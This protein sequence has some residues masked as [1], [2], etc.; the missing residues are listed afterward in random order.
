MKL[1]CYVLGLLNIGFLL[2][3]FH[4]GKLNLFAPPPDVYSPILLV[5]EYARAQ[6][7][8][9]ISSVLDRQSMKLAGSGF[10]WIRDARPRLDSRIKDQPVLAEVK[11]ASPS[12]E[13]AKA[14]AAAP[15]APLEISH[16]YQVGPFTSESLIRQ[17]LD[18]NAVRPQQ[19][20]HTDAV[21]AKDFQVYYPAAKTPEQ[22]RIDKMLL[23]AKGR[24]DAWKI[25]DG[26]L[27]GSYSLGVF[28]DQARAAIFKNQLAEQGIQAEIHARGEVRA[29]WLARLML[30]KNRRRRLEKTGVGWSDCSD[31]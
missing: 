13:P 17:W 15:E 3:Q 11:P 25:P 30:E 24:Q 22:S 1:L 31:H 26:E 9:L 23:A 14:E 18:K 5:D 21:A 7:G 28:R 6:R 29:K 8:A 12:S 19:L 10:E 20:L 2:W 16:C 4:T 27:K